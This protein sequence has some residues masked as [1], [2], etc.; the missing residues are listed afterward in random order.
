MKGDEIEKGRFNATFEILTD[1][2]DIMKE[3]RTLVEKMRDN[4][5]TEIDVIKGNQ[6]FVQ[7]PAGDDF[8]ADWQ[9]NIDLRGIQNIDIEGSELPSIFI[10][11]SWS[12]NLDFEEVGELRQYSETVD[13]STSPSLNQR[14]VLE[15]K[16]RQGQSIGGSFQLRVINQNSNKCIDKFSVPMTFFVPF[17]PMHL[18]IQ[19]GQNPKTKLFLS[20]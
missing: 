8:I 7:I 11:V 6:S 12:P 20:I 9:L 17:R 1:P 4:D 18:E 5:L 15:N 14:L 19:I 13:Q 16:L 2:L 3:S 10:E